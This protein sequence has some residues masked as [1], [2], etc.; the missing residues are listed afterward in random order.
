MLDTYSPKYSL[1]HWRLFSPRSFAS[2]F[3]VRIRVL[4][5]VPCV[6]PKPVDCGQHRPHL[7]DIVRLARGNLSD[8]ALGR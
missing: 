5:D 2:L 3:W 1:L 7:V 4:F 6:R 8:I